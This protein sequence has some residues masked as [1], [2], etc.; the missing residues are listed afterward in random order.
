MLQLSTDKKT[1]WARTV[2]IIALLLVLVLWPGR[3]IRE[4]VDHA[5]P[6]QVMG[7]QR[8]RLQNI[9]GTPPFTSF[10]AKAAAAKHVSAAAR[11]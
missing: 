6:A 5:A 4:K 10:Y 9:R 1:A 2:L 3:L 8:I 11:I 7:L